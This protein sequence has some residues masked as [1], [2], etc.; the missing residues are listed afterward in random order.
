MDFSGELTL[1]IMLLVFHDPVNCK[2]ENEASFGTKFFS[3]G[4]YLEI[5]IVK[6]KFVPTI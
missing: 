3:F 1:V 5:V 6:L 2:E 4:T